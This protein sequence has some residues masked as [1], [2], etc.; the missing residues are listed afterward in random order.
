[1]YRIPRF[2]RRFRYMMTLQDIILGRKVTYIYTDW[3]G[4][5]RMRV[6]AVR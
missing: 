5:Q 6:E 2:W 1:M 3:Q 4:V